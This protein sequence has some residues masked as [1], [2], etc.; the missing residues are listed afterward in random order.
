VGY[1]VVLTLEPFCVSL[2][3]YL[4]LPPL[5]APV[6]CSL[7]PIST[8]VELAPLIAQ[9]KVALTRLGVSSKVDDSNVSL[10]RRCVCP[11]AHGRIVRPH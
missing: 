7:L 3:R 11:S 4:R 8:N 9:M 10:G 2:D 5:M 6:K 1:G